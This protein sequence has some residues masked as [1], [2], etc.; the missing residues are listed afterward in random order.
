M[1]VVGAVRQLPAQALQ[2]VDYRIVAGLDAALTGAPP[3][4]V[5]RASSIAPRVCM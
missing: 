2:G 3:S 4:P 1:E 5:W